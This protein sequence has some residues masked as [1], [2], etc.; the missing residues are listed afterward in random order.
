MSHPGARRIEELAAG[1]LDRRTAGE[2]RDHILDCPRCR[3]ALVAVRPTALFA[4]LGKDQPAP[5]PWDV[6]RRRLRD[7]IETEQEAVAAPPRRRWRTAALAAAAALLAV[8]ILWPSWRALRQPGATRLEPAVMADAAQPGMDDQV[9]TGLSRD[10]VWRGRL[11]EVAAETAL[12]A[13]ENVESLTAR[14]ID[15]GVVSD[16]GMQLVVIVDEEID[17]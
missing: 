13:V 2:V 11:P 6:F 12:P 7:A 17:L 4:L 16:D 8:A 5:Q 9:R 3:E 15:L 14:V 10:G 1:R